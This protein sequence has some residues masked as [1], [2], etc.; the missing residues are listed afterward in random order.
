[1]YQERPKS[2][3]IEMI[4]GCMFAGKSTELIRRLVRYTHGKKRCMMIKHGIDNRYE[5][6]GSKV[7]TH[8]KIE[9]DAVALETLECTNNLIEL[10]N[11]YDV[12]GIDE[13]Q[14]FEDGDLLAFVCR[15]SIDYGKIL[16]ISALNM[17]FKA[18]PYA[19]IAQLAF[20]SESI[21]HLTAICAECGNPEAIF[22]HKFSGDMNTTVEIGGSEFYRPLCRH[23]Y[24]HM[25]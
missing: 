9:Y 19:R 10:V 12:I 5:T 6:N 17:N 18:E 22:T 25:K 24:S 1:M 8:D 23:C 7:I 14:F 15:M 2:G 13:G 21:T 20:V 3:R 4:I 11:E 16:V